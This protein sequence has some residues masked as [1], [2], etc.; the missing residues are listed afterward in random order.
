MAN[1]VDL[2]NNFP[3]P[4]TIQDVKEYIQHL[5]DSK[6]IFDT[7][8]PKWKINLQGGARIK[9]HIAYSSKAKTLNKAQ[10]RRHNKYAMSIKEI[11]NNSNYTNA[12]KIND[13]PFEKPNIAK[14]HYFESSVKINDK[15]YRVILNTEE[16]QGESTKKPQT[17][18]LYDILEVK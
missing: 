15:I 7:L 8:D 14:Y 16:Y 11:I 5:I 17:V 3:T 4:P 10:K 2:S 18:H 6:E 9:N 13:K 1:I 12:P